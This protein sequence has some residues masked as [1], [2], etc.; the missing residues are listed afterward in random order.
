MSVI[1]DSSAVARELRRASEAD[2]FGAI[3]HRLASFGVDDRALTSM[4]ARVTDAPRGQDEVVRLR[5]RV[6]AEEP[7]VPLGAVE[8]YA[9]M[10]VA[11]GALAGIPRLPVPEDVKQL[12][13]DE[14]L[15]LTR[16]SERES[17]WLVAPNYVFSALCKLVTFRRFPA[18]QLHW[19]VSGLQRSASWR[20]RWRD[21]P[22]LARGI[23]SL[24]GFRPAFTPHLAWRRRQIVLSERE[25][26][27]SLFLMAK[28]LELQPDIRG[29][30]GE[31]WFYS[32]DTPRVS[33]H[34][35][36][37]TRLFEQSGGTVV[38]SGRAPENSGVF[39]G[40]RARRQK[41]NA[42]EFQPTIGLVIWP[43]SAMQRWAADD[44]S[45][46]GTRA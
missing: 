36:W 41:A 6:Q 27:R 20:V 46:H 16:P 10:R 4:L 33:P 5:A 45:D 8:R 38:V 22:R 11:L 32:P 30:V 28:A 25:H 9:L 26:R 2:A 12:L 7:G 23:M 19:E 42:G 15:W 29:F 17:G 43:R 1:P 35:A 21:L 13:L 31:A 14:F 24:G 3:R 18:G 39:E 44:A 40:S 37:A 34:L